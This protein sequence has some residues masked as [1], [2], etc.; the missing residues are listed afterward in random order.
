MKQVNG[1]TFWGNKSA[2]FFFASVLNWNQLLENIKMNLA[3]KG[4]KLGVIKVVPL[5]ENGRKT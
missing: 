4:S 3:T 1:Y 2:L 5:C